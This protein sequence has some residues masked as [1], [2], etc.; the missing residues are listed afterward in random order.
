MAE[1]KT[2][3]QMQAI[4]QAIDPRATVHLNYDRTWEITIPTDFEETYELGSHFDGT[5]A[6]EAHSNFISGETELERWA[7][8]NYHGSEPLEIAARWFN[9]EHSRRVESITAF[10]AALVERGLPTIR[11][12]NFEA[13]SPEE[14]AAFK[15]LRE[16]VLAGLEPG[17]K[18]EEQALYA[19]S[20]GE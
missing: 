13:L 17:W 15:A 10:D 11:K 18:A 5:A 16:E 19:L 2:F 1:T 8:K 7:R 3:E 20:S 12:T 9:L 14:Y 6:A 4:A